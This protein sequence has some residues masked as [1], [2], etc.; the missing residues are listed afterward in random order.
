MAY[1]KIYNK[2][3]LPIGVVDIS[4]E[5]PS[6]ATGK[7]VKVYDANMTNAG[8][9][10]LGSEQSEAQAC[11]FVKVFDA[12]LEQNGVVLASQIAPTPSSDAIDLGLPSGTLWRSMN[13]GASTPEEDGM[14]FQWGDTQGYTANQV[15]SGEGY[16]YFDTTY[17]S[18][19]KFTSDGGQSFT[20]YNTSD[21]KMSLETVDDAAY[22]MLGDGWHTPGSRE[23]DELVSST[24]ISF[25]AEGVKGVIF[26]SKSNANSIFLPFNKAAV[27][28]QLSNVY[29]EGLAVWLA[30]KPSSDELALLYPFDEF[31]HGPAQSHLRC[32]GLPIRPVK[33]RQ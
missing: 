32:L 12:N 7:Y 21:G 24:N 3:M 20:K 22:S 30:Q 16:K 11:L 17:W 5:L 28:G 6:E 29:V 13:L 18:D 9:I 19:Y 26:A 14:Y 2:K 1:I 31:Y 25:V 23:F 4:S 10:E 33:F 15:G 27:D 8:V